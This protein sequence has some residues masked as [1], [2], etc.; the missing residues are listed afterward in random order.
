MAKEYYLYVRGQKVA[1]MHVKHELFRDLVTQ[2]IDD[3]HFFHLDYCHQYAELILTLH[4]KDIDTKAGSLEDMQNNI[5][6]CGYG[7]V[8][9]RSL[10]ESGYQNVVQHF[11]IEQH[12]SAGDIFDSMQKSLNFLINLE[13]D[14]MLD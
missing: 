12:Y 6:E 4:C 14:L 5:R 11:A 2:I 13:K 3:C 8:D 10:L 9:F 7:E 1:S